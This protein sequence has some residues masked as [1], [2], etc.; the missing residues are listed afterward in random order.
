[1]APTTR[2]R[3]AGR[4]AVADAKRASPARRFLVCCAARTSELSVPPLVVASHSS[5]WR[6]WQCGGSN[7]T[8]A[9]AL[10]SRRRP[11]L[12]G[13]WPSPAGCVFSFVR[14]VPG[15][16]ILPER[17]DFARLRVCAIVQARRGGLRLPA[18]VWQAS[19]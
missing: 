15:L 3:G 19:S 11:P 1:M 14:F 7:A 5:W 18:A 6:C 10:P 9:I 16:P 2:C 8:H 13:F 12:P 17:P 4:R